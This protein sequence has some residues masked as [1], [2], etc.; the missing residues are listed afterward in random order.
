MAAAQAACGLRWVVLLQL[1]SCVRASSISNDEGRSAARRW[2]SNGLQSQ[3]RDLCCPAECKICGGK[4]SCS[5]TTRSCCTARIQRNCTTSDD[6]SCIIRHHNPQ[7]SEPQAPGA[8][9]AAARSCAVCVVG[10]LSRLELES[11]VRHLVKPNLRAGHTIALL[12]VLSQGTAQYV[13][14]RTRRSKKQMEQIALVDGPFSLAD[15][16]QLEASVWSQLGSSYS[17]AFT[18][19]PRSSVPRFSVRISFEVNHRYPVDL[20]W[21]QRL[22]KAKRGIESNLRRQQLHLLQWSHLRTCMF[23]VDAEEEGKER[24]GLVLKLREDTV[25]LQ[26]WLIPSGWA[27]HGLTSLRCLTH[28]G[29]MDGTFAVGRR[30]AWAIMEGLAA[31]WYIYHYAVK[32][33]S[34]PK[35][36]ET[37]LKRVAQMRHVPMQTRPL[38]ELPFVSVRFVSKAKSAEN[39][40]MDIV[41]K[42][43]HYEYAKNED[44]G[45]YRRKWTEHNGNGDWSTCAS[46][47]F[48]RATLKSMKICPSQLCSSR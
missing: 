40:E 1:L 2:C 43:L 4:G 19:T 16:R 31:D 45:C 38:C 25:A 9:T 41:V 5:T 7:P 27:Q 42:R 36:P 44:H 24:F 6:V 21:A 8:A 28:G 14:S 46:S 48:I 26:P 17:K 34:I 13:N 20:A 37:W 22:D 3:S 23:L 11:K 29:I 39:T 30:W 18:S 47:E 10:Q 35:N 33:K 12:L 15:E 32:N